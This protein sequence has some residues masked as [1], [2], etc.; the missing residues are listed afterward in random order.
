VTVAFED[1]ALAVFCQ[2]SRPDLWSRQVKRDSLGERM[3]H[4]AATMGG[5]GRRP[6][7]I[8]A[9][10]TQTG[11]DAAAFVDI[12]FAD[13]GSLRRVSVNQGIVD[14]S[15]LE[16][17]LPRSADNI[18]MFVTEFSERFLNALMDKR[19]VGMR[20]RQRATVAR[21]SGPESRR[22]GYSYATQAL[23]RL[24]ELVSP[25]LKDVGHVDLSSRL[26]YLTARRH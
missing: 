26:A 4:G 15:G 7:L 20:V 6:S 18:L 13:N 8:E 22:R 17:T 10:G 11:Q 14:F 16:T 12:Y 2:P 3:T 9:L 1:P 21:P 23:S 19:L 24:L 5:V 25:T